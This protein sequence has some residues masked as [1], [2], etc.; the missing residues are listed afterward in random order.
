MDARA[1][2]FQ[3]ETA[4]RFDFLV[5]EYG[6][7]GPDE[8]AEAFLGYVKKGWAVWVGLD[9]CN[10]TVE[11][12]ILYDGGTQERHAP[13]GSLVVAANRGGAQRA[14]TSA[15]TRQGMIASLTRQANI[16]REIMPL[17][18]SGDGY[19]LLERAIR[20]APR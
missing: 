7:Q 6:F 12:E 1:R 14:Q 18:L 15:Q 16:L 11:T 5:R 8:S 17:L 2:D 9:V 20:N 3:K 19:E 4:A 10:R 13:L